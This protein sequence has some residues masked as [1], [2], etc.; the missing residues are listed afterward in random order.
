MLL[1]F[2]CPVNLNIVLYADLGYTVT[3]ANAE[4]PEFDAAYREFVR[5]LKAENIRLVAVNRLQKLQ[6]DVCHEK[7]GEKCHEPYVKPEDWLKQLRIHKFTRNKKTLR[8][9]Y[10]AACKQYNM[11]C[12]CQKHGL[13]WARSYGR[14]IRRGRRAAGTDVGLQDGK[15]FDFTRLVKEY[16]EIAIKII[17]YT[18]VK[19]SAISVIYRFDVHDVYP[20]VQG[21]L[22]PKTG[23]SKRL[24]WGGSVCAIN[25]APL[26][27]DVMAPMDRTFLEDTR[28]QVYSPKSSAYKA[29]ANLK[30]LKP[31]WK[32]KGDDEWVMSEQ[33]RKIVHGIFDML[34]DD[35]NDE[36]ERNSG[37]GLDD[38]NNGG[39]G[40]GQNPGDGEQNQGGDNNQN[41]DDDDSDEDDD[42]APDQGGN[43]SRATPVVS[44]AG[45]LAEDGG[46]NGGN[47]GDIY[48]MDGLEP[49][50]GKKKG[51]GSAESSAIDLSHVRDMEDPDTVFPSIEKDDEKQ[52]V[53]SE[54]PTGAEGTDAMENIPVFDGHATQQHETRSPFGPLSPRQSY[55]P[56]S[57]LFVRQRPSSRRCS[58]SFVVGYLGSPSSERKRSTEGDDED[59][60]APPSLRR[61]LEV[62]AV[63]EDKM[64]E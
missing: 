29:K 9:I 34:S 63:D 41:P 64:E 17:S 45:N 55:T 53:K 32:R 59:T 11:S 18:M 4:N 22:D 26:P 31:L 23:L 30:T 47:E 24:H 15:F 54:D 37:D 38:D 61:R 50:Q 7:Y 57:S 36:G 5:Q 52:E 8:E 49:N 13:G 40:D 56:Q 16:P 2:T 25:S 27:G 43:A 44:E 51:D 20:P 19:H 6:L 1:L 28:R 48:E 21:G 12:V 42:D 62:L 46:E 10:K 14:R 39:G 60:G 35:A 33:V 58:S 3:M